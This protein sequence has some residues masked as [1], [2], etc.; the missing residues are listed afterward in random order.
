MFHRWLSQGISKGALAG[1]KRTRTRPPGYAGDVG[2][3]ATVGV[4]FAGLLVGALA[5]Y[6]SER[7]AVATASR[8]TPVT[9]RVIT[10]DEKA[11]VRRARIVAGII[12]GNH[13]PERLTPPLQSAGALAQTGTEAGTPPKPKIIIIIDD[14]GVDRK[15]S[16]AALSLPGPVTFSFL[17][18]GRQVRDTVK[19]A[20]RAGGEIMLH[21][22]MEPLSDADPGPRALKTGMT[23]GDFLDNLE[24]NLSRFEGYAGVNSHM[25]SK[26]TADLAAMKT[27]L[28]N[29]HHKDLFFLDSLTTEHTA[30][31]EAAREIGVKIYARDVFL[32]DAVGDKESIRQQLALAERIARETGYVVAI[33]HPRKE[34]LE[35]L[36]PWM[37]TAPARGF[38]LAFASDLKEITSTDGP[39]VLA[40]AAPKLRG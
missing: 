1:L 15:Q 36:G 26:L 2:L 23:G 32:D 19:K 14:M 35:V 25:G 12:A 16:E 10:P 34:T 28:A 31:R 3:I 6:L 33:G 40:E 24:W 27:L 17:P 5:A 13:P 21:L 30:A 39:A 11:Q 29:L 20:E 18:Y 37:T 38:D 4:A 22:P 9:E 8:E 7:G